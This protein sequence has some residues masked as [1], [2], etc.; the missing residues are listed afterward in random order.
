MKVIKMQQLGTYAPYLQIRANI[1]DRIRNGVWLPNEKIPVETSLAKEYG[2]SRITIR[3]ALKNLEDEGILISRQGFGRIVAKNVAKKSP[4]RS[5]GV[6]CASIGSAYGEVETINELAEKNGFGVNLYLLPH[7][8]SIRTFAQQ[9]KEMADEQISGIII[10]CLDVFENEI[11]EWNRVIPTVAVYHEHI[12]PN[13]P[14]FFI[15][16]RWMAYEAAN[17]FFDTG[18]DNH[19]LLLHDMA[20]FYQVNH[21]IINAFQYAHHKRNSKLNPELIFKLPSD[22]DKESRKK[23]N[24]I[25]PYLTDGRK[26]GIFSYR[27][28]PLSEIEQHCIEM[29]IKIPEQISLIGVVD[30]ESFEKAPIPITAFQYDR[31]QLVRSAFYSL[32]HHIDNS[33]QEEEFDDETGIYGAMINRAS[34]M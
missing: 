19:I 3:K 34:T 4:K 22:K 29:K 33:V 26:Y 11:V 8:A 6:I 27:S 2:V 13:I 15:N 25:T 24:S 16:W 12:S 20:C 18:F 5:I 31:D 14:S 9:L 21:M 17:K 23:L 30:S 32:M 28:W 10:L 7:I 1:L